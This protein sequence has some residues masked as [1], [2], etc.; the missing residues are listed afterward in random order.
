[1]PILLDSLQKAINSL[2]RAIVRTR[3]VPGD[4]ELRDAVIQRFECTYELAWKMLKRTLEHESPNPSEIDRLSFP[5]LM[6]EG[7]ERGIIAD[8]E[9]WL[10]YRDQRN[11]TSHTYDDKKAESVY[12]SAVVFFDDVKKLLKELKNRNSD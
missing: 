7:A 5:D 3:E 12:K 2:E 10:E 4:K 1:M 8:V 9:V 6:R 11:I